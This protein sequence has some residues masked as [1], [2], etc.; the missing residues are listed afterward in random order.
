MF[1]NPVEVGFPTSSFF[2]ELNPFT[3]VVGNHLSLMLLFLREISV[4]LQYLPSNVHA[5]ERSGNLPQLSVTDGVH[6][7]LRKRGEPHAT[8]PSCTEVDPPPSASKN[9]FQAIKS[10]GASVLLMNM[11]GDILGALDSSTIVVP[12][13]GEDVGLTVGTVQR[14]ILG[15]H[16][17]KSQVIFE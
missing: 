12:R 10:S 15:P 16:L 1:V 3:A 2:N 13:V 7:S 8:Q 14:D 5:I 9:E 11:V 6:G 4:I 17:E